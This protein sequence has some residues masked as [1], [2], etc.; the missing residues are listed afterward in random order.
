M[1]K[2]V[3]IMDLF[4]EGKIPGSGIETI[5]NKCVEQMYSVTMHR[6]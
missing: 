4:F 5:A 3:Q 2:K 1:K 6:F